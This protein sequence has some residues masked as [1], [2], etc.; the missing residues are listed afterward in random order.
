MK[1]DF[2]PVYFS[3]LLLSAAQASALP[4]SDHAV[5][6]ILSLRERATPQAPDGYTPSKVDCPSDRPSIRSASSLS[7][8]E[9][10][11]LEKRRN[12]TV[13]AMKDLLGRLNIEGFDVD[14][15][16]DSA[17]QN[18][19]A[20]PNIAISF[21]GGGWRAMLNG[22]GNLAAFDNRTSNST[23]SGHIGGVLQAATYIVGLSGGNWL[24]GS[25]YTN[26]FTSVEDIMNCDSNNCGSLWDFR[27]SIVVGPDTSGIQLLSTAD[28]YTELFDSVHGKADAGYNTSLTDYWGR[29]L[30]Y[31]L[32]NASNGGPSFTWSS[33]ADDPDFANGLAPMPISVSDGRDPGETLIPVNSTN[34]E[35]NPFEMGSWDPTIFGFAPTKYVGTRFSGGQV[36]QNESCIAGFDNVGFIMGTSSSLFNQLILNVNSTT[37][38]QFLKTA[39]SSILEDIGADENDISD[40]INPFYFW[41]NASNPGATSRRLTLV[42]GGEDGQNIGLSPIVEPRRNVDIIF[43]VD[44]S[45]DTPA[46]TISQNWPNGTSLVASYERSQSDIANGTRFP[47]VPDVNTFVN[48][49]LNTRPTFFGCNDSAEIN[50]RTP[51][52]IYI[53][54]APYVY[55]SNVST[56]DLTYNT[57]ERNA[58]ITNGYDVA[59]MGN[60][61]LDSQWPT[62]VGCAIIARSLER[63]GTTVPDVCQQ[64]MKKYC[65]DG[66]TNSSDAVYNPSLKLQNEQIDVKSAAVGRHAPVWMALVVS[67]VIM[68]FM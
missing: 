54:N 64:C 68:A 62:C 46:G 65:W 47:A 59:T 57:T 60:G 58:I 48:Q 18:I 31:Y 49:G 13:P 36:F 11:W 29:G 26:N 33:I 14:S 40:W 5:S 3:A 22:A 38:P 4:P 19:S 51:L 2:Y 9:Q 34:F 42:D 41:N 37:A 50:A 12:N 32:V 24:T 1:L 6:D 16:L 28:Y 56:F 63:T 35:F 17:S 67:G 45:A 10:S 39:I 20:L 8:Q 61:T 23:S 27:K 66:T 21:S 43:A 7:S 44:S 52:V 25:I 55:N 15:Y 30:S 53:A